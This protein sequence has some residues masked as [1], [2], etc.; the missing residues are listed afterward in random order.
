MTTRYSFEF[1]LAILKLRLF[2]CL[3][4]QTG[5]LRKNRQDFIGEASIMGQFC[6]P[7]VIFLEGVVT[8]SKGPVHAHKSQTTAKA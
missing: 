7:N 5:A 8:K 2:P 3:F 6:D 4:L 1:F